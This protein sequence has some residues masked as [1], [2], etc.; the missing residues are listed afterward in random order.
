MTGG[1]AA[2]HQQEVAGSNNLPLALLKRV[3]KR[4]YVAAVPAGCPD[5]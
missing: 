2:E 1:A 3:R 5:A 4:S